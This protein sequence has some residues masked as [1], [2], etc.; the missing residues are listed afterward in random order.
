MAQKPKP[1][2]KPDDPSEYERFLEVAKEVE[3]SDDPKE[4]ERAFKKV[5]PQKRA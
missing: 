5:I 3:A 2:A 1:S 4:A